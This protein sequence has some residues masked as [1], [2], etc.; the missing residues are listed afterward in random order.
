[1]AQPALSLSLTR[2]IWGNTTGRKDLAASLT[3]LH[4]FRLTQYD[5]I[6]FLDA[7]TLVCRPL[8]PLFDLPHQFAAAPDSGWPDAF[9]SGVMLTTPSQKTFKD[10]IK[11]MDE[12]GSWDGG[13]QGLLNDYFSNWHR[14][15]FTYNVT[16]SAYYT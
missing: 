14:L 9:N 8:S 5:K 13:D 6:I 1:V 3:K 12:R 11:M 10:L 16:P 15:S 2:P 7:D 4:L